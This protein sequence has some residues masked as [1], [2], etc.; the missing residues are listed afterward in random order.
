ML[1]VLP[2]TPRRRT[3]RSIKRKAKSL[4]YPRLFFRLPRCGTYLSGLMPTSTQAT[5]PNADRLR[6]SACIDTARNAPHVG[7]HAS[8][9]GLYRFG[10]QSGYI[11]KRDFWTLVVPSATNFKNSRQPNNFRF[12]GY[13][14]KN[15]KGIEFLAKDEGFL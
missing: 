13:V 7:T 3:P 2:A 8:F 6:Y 1:Y 11:K 10:F 4:G 15:Q 5:P 14:A 9:C 12:S